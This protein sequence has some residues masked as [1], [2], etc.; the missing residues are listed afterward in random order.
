MLVPSKEEFLAKTGGT[1]PMAVYRDILADVETPVSAYWKLAHDQTFSFLLESVTGGEHLARYSFLGIRPR[2]VLRIKD[3]EGR[4][5][6]NGSIDTFTLAQGEDP[7]DALNREMYHKDPVPVPGLPAF[8]GGAVG[9]LSYDIVRYFERLPDSTEDDLQVDDLAMMLADTVV[10]FDHAKNIIRVLVMT[11]GSSE[12]YLRATVE[13]DFILSRLAEPLP[14]LPK[15]SYEV[16]EPKSNVTQE[17]FEGMVTRM[18]EYISEGDGVQMVPAQRFSTR[19]NAHPLTVY[20]AL[21]TI[22]P[23]PYMFLLRFGDFDLVGASPELLVSLH[24]HT[25]RVRPIA[26]TRWRGKDQD[27]DLALEKE[28]LAD[29]K[30]RAEHVMLVDLGR[31]D[32][33]RV[34]EYGTVRVNELMVIERYSHV[35]HIVSDVTGKLR[36]EKSAFDLFRATHPAGTVSGAPKVRAMEIIDELEPTRRGSY[37]GSVGFFSHTGELDTCIAIRTIFIKNGMAH[38][39]AGGGVVYDSNPTKEY[40]E[41]KNKAKASL[42]AI[43]MAQRGL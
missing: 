11:D 26:G 2:S 36:K 9:L 34:C 29:E 37:A 24:G 41:S 10:I 23:S 7:L 30:E 27:E 5:E 39:Q 15:G 18:I 28:L 40:E 20:R 25:A 31:N 38:V 35:M 6:T 8:A 43:E 14:S 1:R 33:G 3:G 16:E 12:S 22:N 17:Q 32:L 19:V 13:I 42:R 4:R 21:R